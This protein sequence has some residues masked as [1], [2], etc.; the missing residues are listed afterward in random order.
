MGN[1]KMVNQ[2]NKNNLQICL[3]LKN[4]IFTTHILST[5]EFLCESAACPAF[6]DLRGK[7]DRWLGE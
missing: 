7:N 1:V 5:L 6:A 4:L 3:E 2:S